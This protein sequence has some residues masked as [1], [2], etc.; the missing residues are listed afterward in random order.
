MDLSSWESE[1]FPKPPFYHHFIPQAFFP[2]SWFIYCLNQTVIPCPVQRQIHLPLNVFNRLLLSTP[3]SSALIELG[4]QNGRLF[5]GI[6]QGVTRSVKRDNHSSLRKVPWALGT[7]G[8]N[9][10]FMAAS[11]LRQG[12]GPRQVQ[13]LQNSLTKI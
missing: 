4:E 7:P 3:K 2:S 6:F 9:A 5:E 13:M 10:V 12:M 1:S 11:E 8:G